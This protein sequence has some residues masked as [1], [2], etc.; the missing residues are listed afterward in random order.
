M[1]IYKDNEQTKQELK[2]LL[3]DSNMTAKQV[4]DI[5]EVKPQQ[6][7]NIV[8]KKNLSLSDVAKIAEA[9]GHL[10]AIDFIKKD[11]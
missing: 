8:N 11:E 10:L 1:Y 7:N 3:I 4:A 5:M 6:Y 9:T 2:K